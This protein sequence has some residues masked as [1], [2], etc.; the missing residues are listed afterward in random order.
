M[1]NLHNL[2]NQHEA[3]KPMVVCPVFIS[4]EDFAQLQ[5]QL[6]SSSHEQRL[7]LQT[8][9]AWHLRQR[10]STQALQICEQVEQALAHQNPPVTAECEASYQAMLALIR[11]EARMLLGELVESRN[12]LRSAL[13]YFSQQQQFAAASDALRILALLATEAGDAQQTE[14]LLVQALRHAQLA[15]DRQRQCLCQTA[16]GIGD[17]LKDADNAMQIWG[18]QLDINLAD[19]IE[20]AGMHHFYGYCH[21]LKSDLAEAITHWINAHDFGMKSGQLRLAISSASNAGVAFNSLNEHHAA[22]EWTES[23]LELARRNRWPSQIALGLLQTADTLRH[24]GQ[25]DAAA[26]L[27]EEAERGLVRTPDSRNYAL[28]LTYQGE[29]AQDYGDHVTALRFFS[30]ARERAQNLGHGDLVQVS[31]RGMAQALLANGDAQQALQAAQRAL[32][33]AQQRQDAFNEIDS[34]KVLAK[35]HA[36]H[37]LPGPAEVAPGDIPLHYLEQAQELA[38]NITGYLMGDSLPQALGNEYA[39]RGQFLRAYNIICKANLDR[40]KAHRQ[41]VTNRAVAMRVQHQ[42]ASAMAEGE[43]HRRLALSEARRSAVLQQTSDTLERLCEIGGEIASKLELPVVFEALARHVQELLLPNSFLVFLKDVDGQHINLVFG[44]EQGQRLAPHRLPLSDQDSYTVR[45]L[46]ER[47]ELVMDRSAEASLQQIIGTL[48][49]LSALYVP[50]VVGERVFGVVSAQSMRRFAFG[51]REQLVFRTLCAYGAIALDNAHA[52]RQLHDARAHLVTQ[53]KLAAL[54]SLVA[55]VAHELNTPLGNCLMITSALQATNHA[56]LEKMDAPGMRRA[57]LDTFLAEHAEATAVIMRGLT[58]A[59]ELVN[60][61]KQVALDRSTAQRRIFN[62]LQTSRDIIATL[63][64]QIKH[65]GHS[66]TLD[67]PDDIELTSYP[68]PYGQIITNFIN[69]A[70]LHAFDDGRQGGQ[71]QLSAR[72][73]GEDKVEIIFSDDGV[74]IAPQHLS[75]IFDPFFTTKMGKGGSGL[76]MSISYN[77]ITSILQGSIQVESTVG[78]GTQFILQFPLYVPAQE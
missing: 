13:Q 16:M 6:L 71:M 61:F 49:C 39:R 77:L 26:P 45:C 46:R 27:L 14:D 51:E 47:R 32:S 19:P 37:Q 76:G 29:L 63:A 7:P 41:E 73:I 1:L 78:Q 65:A 28:A 48:P 12:L 74:G 2:P 67:M 40:D 10:D 62:L 55:G 3:L 30:K 54:G 42:T 72:R 69:N 70:M 53:E 57:D 17:A 24:Q 52:Y 58:S 23:A 34:L 64:N 15:Q 33:L 36:E 56:M 68:G 35:I 20:A 60:S 11:G 43:H 8:A 59:T 38:N 22:M 9:L 18:P 21:G 4:N 75:R 66:I 5:A 25:L 50:L 31:E 44:I